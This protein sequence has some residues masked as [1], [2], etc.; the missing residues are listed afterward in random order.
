MSALAPIT[1]ARKIGESLRLRSVIVLQ[2]MP[3]GQWGY[4]SWGRN[5]ADCTRAQEIADRALDIAEIEAECISNR[6]EQ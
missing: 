3:D 6:S 5:R 4:T 1:W 2:E